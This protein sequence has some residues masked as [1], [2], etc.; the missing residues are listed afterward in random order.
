MV[1]GGRGDDHKISSDYITGESSI[2]WSNLR[3]I[4]KANS[5][6]RIGQ[7]WRKKRWN[8]GDADGVRLCPAFS[9]I[10]HRLIVADM[11]RVDPHWCVVSISHLTICSGPR[12]RVNKSTTVFVVI[13]LKKRPVSQPVQVY[14]YRRVCVCAA[15]TCGYL[16]MVVYSLVHI[17]R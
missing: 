13:P 6:Q 9:G 5:K 15:V 4:H 11:I 12:G 16:L 3:Y 8:G 14:R 17:G 2:W 7:R 1:V 10:E